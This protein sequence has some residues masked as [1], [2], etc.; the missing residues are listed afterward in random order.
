MH[1]VASCSNQRRRRRLRDAPS[2]SLPLSLFCPRRASNTCNVIIRKFRYAERISRKSTWDYR[3]SFGQIR[4]TQHPQIRPCFIT[5]TRARKRRI[6][7][8][9]FPPAGGKIMKMTAYCPRGSLAVAR[10]D[11]RG[12][13]DDRKSVSGVSIKKNHTVDCWFILRYYG[14]GYTRVQRDSDI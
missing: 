4:A 10:N 2:P 7:D 6:Y 11:D 3:R 14:A 8:L 1:L 9:K 5:L 13:F 12:I